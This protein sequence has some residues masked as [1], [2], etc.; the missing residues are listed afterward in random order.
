MEPRPYQISAMDGIKD[1]WFVKHK[2]IV[3]LHLATG[4]GKTAIFSW[5]LSRLTVPSL[6][7]VRGRKLVNQAHLRL[8]A[9]GVPHGVHMANHWLNLPSALV[10]IASVDTLIARQSFPPAQVIVVDEAHQAESKGYQEVLAQYP[11]ALILKVTATPYNGI[12]ADE[13]IKP[14]SLL[15]LIEEGYLVRPRYFP[16]ASISVKGVKVQGGEFNQVQLAAAIDKGQLIDDVVARYKKD[17]GNRPALCFAVNVHHS[18]SIAARF[19]DAGITAIHC[20]A[21]TSDADR[22]YILEESR[23]GR[24][25]VICNVGIYT[26]GA[27]MPWISCIIDAAPTWSYIRNVQKWGRG[28]RIYGPK[29]DFIILDHAGNLLRHGPIETEPDAVI[30]KQEIK[31]RVTDSVRICKNIRQDGT[32]CATYFKGVRCPVCGGASVMEIKSEHSGELKEVKTLPEEQVY[33]IELKR[34]RKLKKYRN[35]WVYHA[36]KE[37]Y[38]D[39]VSQYFKPRIVP[40]WIRARLEAGK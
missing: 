10:Q 8:Q 13:V 24:I 7:L 14:I 16:P 12:E 27:D 40:D 33:L 2:C 3:L 39:K 9:Q 32:M 29:S 35:G 37:K 15:E 17:G 26:T 5:I 1:A 19:R 34:T 25:S 23:L 4:A 11:N 21:D 36:F 31:S 22:E 6:M 30:G 18:Q 28:T 20:D 38:P